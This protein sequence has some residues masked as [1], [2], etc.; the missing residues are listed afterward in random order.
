MMRRLLVP[1]V[2]TM[3]LYALTVAAVAPA[4]ALVIAL[5]SPDDYINNAAPLLFTA[6]TRNPPNE[7][8]IAIA[9]TP[10]QTLT[11]TA[12]IR[13]TWLPSAP[14][15][16]I[17]IFPFHLTLTRSCSDN[18]D[19]N[20]ISA[21][22]RNGDFTTSVVHLSADTSAMVEHR[23]PGYPSAFRVGPFDAEKGGVRFLW[24]NAEGGWIKEMDCSFILGWK[25]QFRGKAV[26]TAAADT[27][28]AD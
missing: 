8:L 10:T 19:E 12:Q 17:L 9:N 15:N 16:P 22:V 24:E 13:Q 7:A 27:G 21:L 3:L 5:E 1:L 23:I 6:P 25:S 26:A 2:L 11:K 20:S 4:S 14:K 28:E 18:D